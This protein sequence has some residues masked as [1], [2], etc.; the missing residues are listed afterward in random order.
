MIFI[1]NSGHLFIIQAKL[2]HAAKKV[3]KESAV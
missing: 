2:R 1:I 3:G